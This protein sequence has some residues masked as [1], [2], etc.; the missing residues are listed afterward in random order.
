MS[1]SPTTRGEA[2]GRGEAGV[3]E[4][5]APLP[6]KHTAA[7]V[8]RR[9]PLLPAVQCGWDGAGGATGP[10][11]LNQLPHPTASGRSG[12]FPLP[13]ARRTLPCPALPAASSTRWGLALLS[14][15]T[16]LPSLRRALCAEGRRLTR[17]KLPA[18]V[19]PPRVLSGHDNAP[20]HSPEYL[21]PVSP[22]GADTVTNGPRGAPWVPKT[23]DAASLG[24][25]LEAGIIPSERTDRKSSTAET[26]VLKSVGKR[27]MRNPCP[28]IEGDG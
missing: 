28:H 22:Q 9:K 24:S 4:R 11:D 8:H 18:A 14:P 1:R 21:R 17:V 25:R 2:G 13:L 23:R 19:Q 20:T 26:P 16:S 7:L 27:N 3:Q 10:D 15:E 6:C 12:S 5:A